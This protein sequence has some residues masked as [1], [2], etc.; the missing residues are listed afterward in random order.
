MM[1]AGAGSRALIRVTACANV[2]SAS[3]FAAPLKPMCV[4][5]ICTKLKSRRG[6][7]AV[8]GRR[9]RDRR[10]P[11]VAVQTSPVPAQAMHCRNPRRSTPSPPD[12]AASTPSSTFLSRSLMT[13]SSPDGTGSLHD[14]RAGH[15]RMQGAKVLIDARLRERV[16]IPLAGFQACRFEG[17]AGGDYGVHVFVAIQPAHGRPRWHRERRAAE[18]VLGDLDLR[19][20]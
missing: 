11:P 20:R 7:A 9:V 14:D 2:P 10:T 6:S 4:S 18:L 15:Q 8:A 19:S 17:L 3:V 1:N 16:R 5:L 13:R 12:T